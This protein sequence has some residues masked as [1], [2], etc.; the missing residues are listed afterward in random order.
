MQIRSHF[1]LGQKVFI[2]ESF[3]KQLFD[4]CPCCELGKLKTLDGTEFECPRCVGKG[5]LSSSSRLMYE[6]SSPL[7]IGEIKFEIGIDESKEMYMCHET[8]VGGGRV[9]DCCNIFETLE[10]AQE[11]ADKRN[12]RAGQTWVCTRCVPKFKPI[13]MLVTSP[14]RDWKHCPIHGNTVH[15]EIENAEKTLELYVKR[16]QERLEKTK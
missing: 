13:D 6:E 4:K 1:N 14:F 10:L 3:I 8:G 7:T 9:Y 11:D 2:V 5:L 12:N 15:L 16:E